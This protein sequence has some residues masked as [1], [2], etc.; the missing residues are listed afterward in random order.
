MGGQGDTGAAEQSPRPFSV[1]GLLAAVAAAMRLI[2]AHIRVLGEAY[3]HL[4]DPCPQCRS[5]LR[6]GHGCRVADPALGAT[7]AARTERFLSI[8]ICACRSPTP[9]ED[10][11]QQADWAAP[12][13]LSAHRDALERS[14]STTDISKFPV[15]FGGA[16]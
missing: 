8:Y 10:S 3:V 2:S 15:D 7:T 14:F 1:G 11:H 6:R 12:N 9:A 4:L 5:R 16:F 13:A